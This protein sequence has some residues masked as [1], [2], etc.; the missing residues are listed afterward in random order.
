MPR[1]RFI[2]KDWSF[3]KLNF[4]TNR[5]IREINGWLSV[6]LMD[7]VSNACYQLLISWR[8]PK[9]ILCDHQSTVRPW[10]VII[11]HHTAMD[12]LFKVSLEASWRL[13]LWVARYFPIIG[14]LVF[15]VFALFSFRLVWCRKL[16][17]TSF[18]IRCL[19]DLNT[20]CDLNFLNFV[21]NYAQF[22]PEI[23]TEDSLHLFFKSDVA[24]LKTMQH[25]M[26]IP[27]LV[28]SILA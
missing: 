27:Y 12:Q 1:D 3:K 18:I 20:S 17:W 28:F 19:I 21:Q 9:D 16:R 13:L 8:R 6:K 26:P 22:L 14:C 7:G 24:W 5:N 15:I 23:L 25:E 11:A 10:K 4:I 2:I